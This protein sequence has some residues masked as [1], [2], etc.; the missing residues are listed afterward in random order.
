VVSYNRSV[1]T[2]ES[3]VLV[4]ARKFVELKAAS[5]DDGELATLEPVEGVPRGLQAPELMALPPA[6]NG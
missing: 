2:L 1:G 4:T 6:A 3:R 5:P